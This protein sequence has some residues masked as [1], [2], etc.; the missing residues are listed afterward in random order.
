MDRESRT[1]GELLQS[2][3]AEIPLGLA[4]AAL[5]LVLGR[6]VYGALF[7]VPL[8]P[9]AD[10]GAVAHLWQLLM[11]GQLLALAFFAVKWL[12][13][14]PRQ[15]AGVLAL[16]MGAALAAMAPVYFLHL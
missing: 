16:E 6:L 12:P 7:H 3:S 1:F 9:A 2:P 11:A 13:R 4:L 14:L 15:A 8:A 10:E 5:A